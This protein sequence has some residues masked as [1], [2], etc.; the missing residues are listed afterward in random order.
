MRP[1]ARRGGLFALI[2][3]LVLTV[4]AT[5][6]RA[7]PLTVPVEVFFA[8]QPESLEDFMAVFAV[9]REVE[10]P[11]VGTGALEQLIA[12]PSLEEQQAGYFSE[13]GEMLQGSSSCDGPDFSLSIVAGLATLR[14]CREVVSAGIGQ[15]ARVRSQIEATLKQFATV[16][17]VRLLSPT[18]HCLF[19]ES[20]LDRCFTS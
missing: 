9:Q 6:A 12:G 13:L 18:G 1:A 19:D 8:R 16:Q 7:A 17:T 10:P 4:G 20:G 11:R 3:L 2:A 5:P 15:D 14:F